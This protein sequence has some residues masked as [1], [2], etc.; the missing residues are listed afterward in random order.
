MKKALSS[1]AAQPWRFF[2]AG[3]FDQVRIDSGKELAALDKLD[4]KL[5]VALA[6]PIDNVNFDKRTLSL[7]DRDN[8]RRIRAD[9]LIAAVSWTVSRLKNPDD[10]VKASDSFTLDAISK[11]DEEGNRLFTAA[12]NALTVLGKSDSDTLTVADTEK[13]EHLMA[14]QKFNGDGIITEASTD[15]EKLRTC[16]S[17]IA[18]TTGSKPDR[19][20]KAGIDADL[21]EAFY[22]EALSYTTWFSE[23]ENSTVIKPFGDATGDAAAALAAVSAKVDDYFVRCQIAVFDYRA[24]GALDSPEQAFTSLGSTVLSLS[25]ES[26]GALPLAHVD[27]KGTLPLGN[28]SNPA[29]RERISSFVRLV[30]KPVLGTREALSEND[31][32]QIKSV[33]APFL[34][35]QERKP[36]SR[37]ESL[38]IVRIRSLMS[39]DERTGLTMLFEKE[40]AETPTFAALID[41][42]KLVR[43][44]RDLY[45][46]CS[47]FVNFKDFYSGKNSALFQAGT[48]FLDQ[49]SCALC[50]TVDDANKHSQMAAMAGSYLVYCECRRRA[51]AEKIT[52]VAAF[53]NGDSENL[54]T[55]RNG[56]FYDHSGNDWDATVIKIIE[57]PISI[58]QAFWLPYKNLVRMIESQVAKRATAAEAQST[59]KL[60]QTAVATAMLDTQKPLPPSKKVDVGT[61]AAIG[62][63]AGAIGTFFATLMGYASGIIRLGPF[64]ILGALLGVLLLISGPS[65]ILAYIKLRKR[66]LGPILDANGW[67]INAKACINV[68][69]G[70]ALTKC[71]VLPPGSQR[72]LFD[73]YAAKKSAWPK[74]IIFI[75]ALWLAWFALDKSGILDRLIGGRPQVLRVLIEKVPFLRK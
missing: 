23:A 71:A 26:L 75:T 14:Q 72:D 29:W 7:I 16:I 1:P 9:E 30:V 52:I 32:Q 62:V 28:D 47:N 34:L 17:D 69:F 55:G 33:F 61:V 59:A 36:V 46:L 35:W 22:K 50:M 40:A 25:N 38:G 43:F 6:C 12:R 20:G 70:A 21:V 42:E 65:L 18:A 5:W 37:I 31:W 64:A 54:M 45:R 8:D 73:P 67:A 56:L 13:I 27:L 3:G 24:A 44:N 49:R 58:R 11:A 41:L 57:N 51:G 4:R 2:R 19:S 10:L 66:S 68:P 74:I 60:E 48:L 39:G 53:T 63:A 15:D